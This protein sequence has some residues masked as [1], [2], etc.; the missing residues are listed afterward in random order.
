[1]CGRRAFRLSLLLLVWCVC[2]AFEEIQVKTLETGADLGTPAC[3]NQTIHKMMFVICK[4]DRVI[5]SGNECKVARRFDQNGTDNT[6]DPRVTLQIESDRVFLNITNIQPSDEGSYTC[7]CVHNRGR[8]FFNLNISVNGSHVTNILSFIRPFN[9]MIITAFAGFVAVVV[10]VGIIRR[11][12][13]LNRRTQQKAVY[14]FKEEE[15]QDI[16]P[17]NTLTSRDNGIYSTL[18]LTPS[19]P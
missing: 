15:Q 6:C 4:V 2:T 1:M 11:K 18:Q 3:P 9:V 5:S 12:C 17:Y 8:H 7:E 13:N 19:N 16:D 10:L 14:T